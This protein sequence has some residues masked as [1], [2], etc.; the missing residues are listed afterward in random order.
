MNIYQIVLT[1]KEVD[2]VNEIG[3]QAAIK[4]MPKYSAYLDCMLEGSRNYKPE[5][6]QYFTKV[7]SVDTTDLE[8]CFRLTNL[9]E[10]MSRV[11]KHTS[12]VRSTSVGD[13]VEVEPNLYYI[14]EPEGW[15]VL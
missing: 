14:C 4:E 1:K 7:A 6:F 12:S 8:E 3:R 9:W 2:R 11:K 15:S 10:D 13:I 5:Y